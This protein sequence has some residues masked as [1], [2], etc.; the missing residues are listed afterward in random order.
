MRGSPARE[1]Y[2]PWA[3][4]AGELLPSRR[5][6]VSWSTSNERATATCDP[7]GQ[8]AGHRGRPARTVLT[9]VLQRSSGQR[10]EASG[11]RP[12]MTP[13]TPPGAGCG[14]SVLCGISLVPPATASAEGAQLNGRP[15]LRVLCHVA[16][17]YLV[18]MPGMQAS[19]I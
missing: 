16:A 15:S 3:S 12:A 7:C 10:H 6:D 11:P 1:P 8:V 2:S 18:S 13:S 14:V 4:K 19:G 17:H 5:V 9:T